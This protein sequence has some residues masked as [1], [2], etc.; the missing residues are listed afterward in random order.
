MEEPR[1]R[2]PLLTFG[3]IAA[4]V[5]VYLSLAGEPSMDEAV[6]ARYWIYPNPEKIWT[7]PIGRCSA[8][9][10]PICNPSFAVQHGLAVG[11]GSRIERAL[12]RQALFALVFFGAIFSSGAQLAWSGRVWR[13]GVVYTL[14]GSCSAR[15]GSGLVP[16]VF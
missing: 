3:L 6:L 8:R 16:P 2:I 7:G 9:L 11:L 15:A 5:L 14:F 10:S 13:L 4:N 1:A 12:G